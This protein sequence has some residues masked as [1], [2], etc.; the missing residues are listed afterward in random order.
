MP[1][2]AKAKAK[3]GGGV[4]ASIPKATAKSKPT[5]KWNKSWSRQ[6]TIKYLKANGVKLIG[7]NVESHVELNKMTNNMRQAYYSLNTDGDGR[8]DFNG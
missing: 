6:K 4:G 7:E 5:E 1:P 8:P 3:C 2:K